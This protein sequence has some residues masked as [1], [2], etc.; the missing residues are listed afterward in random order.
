MSHQVPVYDASRP[1]LL[2]VNEV[3]ALLKISRP[4]VYRM[5]RRGELRPYRVGE[6]LRF[7]AHEIDEL[8]ER[9]RGEP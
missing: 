6:R 2:S 7:N 9:S 8:L 3:A 4:S 1:A 5:I